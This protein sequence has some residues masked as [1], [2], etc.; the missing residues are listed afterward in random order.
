MTK[1][2]HS[3]APAIV[4]AA[5]NGVTSKEKNPNVPRSAD[6]I[7][8]DTWR[9]LE[10]GATILHARNREIQLSGQAAADDYLSAWREILAERP[11]TLWYPTLCAAATIEERLLHMEILAH[12]VPVPI[13]AVDPGSTNLGWPDENRLPVG[14][15]YANAYDEIRYS[16]DLCER[17]RMAPA[18][19]IYEPG[20][21]RT[22]L[23]YLRAGRLPQGR[24]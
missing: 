9:C 15:V 14:L 2:D 6:E 13:C 1:L 5:I 20:F 3:R 16:F 18:L 24:W 8:A 11:D 7:V 17:Q 21:L 12:E 23:V 22:V 10:A 19:A 4:E